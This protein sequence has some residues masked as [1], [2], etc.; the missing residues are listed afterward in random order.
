MKEVMGKKLSRNKELH[1]FLKPLKGFR[2]PIVE[3]WLSTARDF[4]ICK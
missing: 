3:E 1:T 4:A 2:L